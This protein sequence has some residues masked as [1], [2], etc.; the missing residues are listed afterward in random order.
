MRDREKKNATDKK[1]SDVLIVKKKNE[2]KMRGELLNKS[3]QA[4]TVANNYT[5][6][7]EQLQLVQFVNKNN[8]MK[9]NG[10]GART[11]Q[12]RC[13]D[14]AL[15]SSFAYAQQQLQERRRSQ[16][17]IQVVLKQTHTNSAEISSLHASIARWMNTLIIAD[18]HGA[19]ALWNYVLLKNKKQA[20]V[21]LH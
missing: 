9:V 8:G 21:C 13:Y 12:C 10:N 3:G 16:N 18:M 1:L 11:T 17:D 15:T 20:K 5:L 19:D 2:W 6:L 14:V 7:T 4:T